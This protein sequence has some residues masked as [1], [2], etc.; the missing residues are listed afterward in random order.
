MAKPP[1]QPS[2]ELCQFPSA[3]LIPGA[4]GGKSERGSAALPPGLWASAVSLWS[5]VLGSR[6]A[7]PVPLLPPKPLAVA[8]WGMVWSW[9]CLHPARGLQVPAGLRVE[10]LVEAFLPFAAWYVVT[11]Q[12]LLSTPVPSSPWSL[13]SYLSL[14]PGPFPFPVHA[15]G[16]A[17]LQPLSAVATAVKA[18]PLACPCSIHS[19][20]CLNQATNQNSCALPSM[21]RHHLLPSKQ[22]SSA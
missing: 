13:I 1:S 15:R 11:G 14:G 8:R 20:S 22:S 12:F 7:L 18:K 10:Q 3:V 16:L 6:V 9:W 5:R 2:P 19:L 21:L 17:T 4:A